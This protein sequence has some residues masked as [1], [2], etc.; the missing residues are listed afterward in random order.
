MFVGEEY[1]LFLLVLLLFLFFLCVACDFYRREKTE[2]FCFSR[3]DRTKT[4]DN[5]CD[6]TR[7]PHLKLIPFQG[8]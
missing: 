7:V 3:V 1:F 4:I 8:M 6:R 5:A 2:D